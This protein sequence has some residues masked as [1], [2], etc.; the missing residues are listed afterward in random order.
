MTRLL[1]V[2]MISALMLSSCT[3]YHT[4]YQA[5]TKIT[6]TTVEYSNFK[7]RAG[8]ISNSKG[9]NN[10]GLL[11]SGLYDTVV[12][13]DLAAFIQ[14]KMKEL[15]SEVHIQGDDQREALDVL[16]IPSHEM[17]VHDDNIRYSQTVK[18]IDNVGKYIL[19]N[20]TIS[21]EAEIESSSG[22][23]LF[24]SS[25]FWPPVFGMP[26]YIARASGRAERNGIAAEKLIR[27]TTEQMVRNVANNGKM[28]SF[29]TRKNFPILFEKQQLAE[30]QDEI[31]S[32]V[33]TLPV[34][35]AKP[36]KNRYAVVIGIENYRQKLQKAD[37]ATRDA[38]KVRDYLTKV[39]G[40][41]EENVITLLNEQ[42]AK[43]DLEKYL[44]Q[45]LAN[46]VEKDGSVFIYYSGHGT[47]NPANGEA[48]LV[49]YDGDPTFIDQTGYSLKRLYQSVSRLPAKTKI[50]CLDSCF[51]GAGGKSVMAQGTR[52]AVFP[53]DTMPVM[54]GDMI[55]ITS[56]Q[57][58]Q[59]STSY[60]EKGHGLFTYYLLRGIKGALDEDQYAKVE[61]GDLY[62]YL[63]PQ[64][65]RMSRKLY[66]AEQS[67]LLL[68][69]NESLRTL[70]LR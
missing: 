45:W 58:S 22:T 7:V 36:V 15:F 64:V 10:V 44:D 57:G 35:N 25:L 24:F 65:E 49:P 31:V 18:I 39:L 38:K 52:P 66:N 11:D 23:G 63:K 32:D 26:I 1:A 17:N 5:P 51:S 8:I 13:M 62:N 41:P 56:S 19:F 2:V 3:Q 29:D 55:V 20:E 48:Y 67:P 46:N 59:I 30:R 70:G 33:D 68:L 9:E 21:N 47:P 61:V 43:S 42:A 50:V 53:T 6:P 12:Q 16:V 69:A 27:T 4:A 34:V 60:A 14:S 37:Y 54:T 40:Y 28:L